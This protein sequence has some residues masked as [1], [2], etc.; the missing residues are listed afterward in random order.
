MLHR[1]FHTTDSQRSWST[2][3]SKPPRSREE[4][5]AATAFILGHFS[6]SSFLDSILQHGL[7]PDTF[8]ERSVDDRVPSDNSSVYLAT[9]YDRF[10]A[11]RAAKHHM[12][13]PIIVEVVVERSKLVAD[14]AALSSCDLETCTPDD[15]LYRSLC[16]GVCKHNGVISRS[17]ILSISGLDGSVIFEQSPPKKNEEA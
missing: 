11:E 15:A 12:G 5:E 3:R 14:E 16:F 6:S 4:F 9:T 7:I 10:Y 1:C 2:Y 13:Q 8:K 17:S